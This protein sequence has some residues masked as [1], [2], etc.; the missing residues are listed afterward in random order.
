MKR[1]SRCILPETYP[2]ISFNEQGLCSFCSNYR[3]FVPR[4]E[5]I[6][7]NHIMRAKEKKR[8]YDAIVPLSGG[9]DSTYVLYLA[10]NV[11]GLNVLAYTF[12]NGFL[13]AMALRNIKSAVESLDIPHISHR[14]SR[15][16]LKKL[17]RSVLLRTG[18]LCSVCGIGIAHGYLKVSEDWRIPL[19]LEGSSASEEDSYT[20]ERIYDVKR[21][22]AVLRDVGD[23]TER[24][25]SEFLVYDDLSPLH[26]AAYAKL[27]RFG[28]VTQPLLHMPKKK[29]EDI[30]QILREEVAWEDERDGVRARKHFDC[31]AEPFTNYVREHRLGYSRR[32]CQ[33][34]AMIRLGE[35]TREEALRKLEEESPEKEPDATSRI[36]EELELSREQLGQITKIPLFKFDKYCYP[37]VLQATSW[38]GIWSKVAEA[39]GSRIARAI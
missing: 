24:E 13:T 33:Y 10:R 27:G 23:V 21:F 17:Y 8:T 14:P 12:D 3:G 1:C 25:V 18:E 20:P 9:K 26:Q 4:P 31:W 32:V 38:R 15:R 11:Y 22:K 6:L 39:A 28:K 34:S 30:R 2:G 35:M 29:S 36:L 16:I 7:T 37:S 5:E 19:I